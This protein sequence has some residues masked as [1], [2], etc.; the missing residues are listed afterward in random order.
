MV[1]ECFKLQRLKQ[2]QNSQ[3]RFS[4]SWGNNRQQVT[5]TAAK[6]PDL[7]MSHQVEALV[8]LLTQQQLNGLPP[9]QLNTGSFAPIQATIALLQVTCQKMVDLLGL[10]TPEH[11]TIWPT[12]L[13]FFM[14]IISLLFLNLLL[15]L[16]V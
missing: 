8:Q 15:L 9:S 12:T 16:M 4:P 14:S 10:L 7:N 6:N 11:P 2:Q 3:P 13:I 5:N 1:T